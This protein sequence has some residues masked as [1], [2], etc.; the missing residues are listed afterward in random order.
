MEYKDHILA[1][2]L[3]VAHNSKIPRKENYIYQQNFRLSYTPVFNNT[4]CI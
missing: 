1:V 3:Y 4:A 2:M